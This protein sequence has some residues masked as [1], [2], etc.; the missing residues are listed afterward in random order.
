MNIKNRLKKLQS[1]IITKDSEFCGCETE[2]QTVVLI[3]T[4]DGKGKALDGETYEEPPEFCQTCGKPNP[5][6][7]Y[8]TFTIKPSVNLTGEA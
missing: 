4:A 1:Q 6:R 8:I 5:E 7:V 3:P 2:I